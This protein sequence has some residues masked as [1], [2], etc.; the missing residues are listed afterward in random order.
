M[1]DAACCLYFVEVFEHFVVV[2]VIH[3]LHT[4][5]VCDLLAEVVVAGILVILQVC[6]PV[7]NVES[8][9]VLAHAS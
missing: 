7:D 8:V 2:W 5:C 3:L 4:A 1:E 6:H 9:V